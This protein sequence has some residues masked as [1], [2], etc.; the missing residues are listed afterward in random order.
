MTDHPDAAHAA[1]ELDD[2]Q[3][4]QDRGM[5]MLGG[6]LAIAVALTVGGVAVGFALAHWMR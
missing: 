4:S 6:L 3:P 5:E 2:G 1:S